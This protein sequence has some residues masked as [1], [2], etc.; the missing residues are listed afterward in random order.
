MTKL[1]DKAFTFLLLALLI[2]FLFI[3][4]HTVVNGDSMRN[5]YQTGDRLFLNLVDR[6]YNRG[7]IVTVFNDNKGAGF[8]PNS[9]NTIVQVYGGKRVILVKRVIGLPGEEIEMIDKKI[10]IY[11]KENP[12]GVLINEDKYAKLDWICSN[13]S[14][15]P[16]L[17]FS[18]YKIPE[19]SYFVM[20]DNRGCSQDS[21]YYKAF[22]KES[23]LGKVILKLN[24]L[25]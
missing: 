15:N 22:A 25:W 19:G 10:I 14:S 17:S 18:K 11:N 5:T 20:G 4:N 21:R 8:I 24:W 9:I 16:E 3:I 1:F 6:N 13:G 23:I 2:T 7:D 12:K